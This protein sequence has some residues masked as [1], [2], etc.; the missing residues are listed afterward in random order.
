M[1]A[2]VLLT[3]VA[4]LP[5]LTW[6]ESENAD[7]APGTPVQ[8][9]TQERLQQ[10]SSELGKT[11]NAYGPGAVGLQ[12]GLLT[13][14]IGAGAVG[15]SEVVVVGSSSEAGPDYLRFRIL[16]GL[17]FDSSQT[18]EAE[19]LDFI[20][21][22]IATPALEATETFVMEPRG[23]ELAFEYGLQHFAELPDHKPD[24]TAPFSMRTITI[25]I[26]PETVEDYAARALTPAELRSAARIVDAAGDAGGGER[27]EPATAD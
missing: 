5:R 14:T 21:S 25:A 13:N 19:R 16:T 10:L 22:R 9:R 8:S 20:W 6:A 15:P 26:G 3:A 27:A 7:P 2:V 12:V 1:A 17:I 24:A 11:A 23:L 18:T 4:P